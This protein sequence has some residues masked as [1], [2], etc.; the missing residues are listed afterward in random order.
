[1]TPYVVDASVI[2]KWFIPERHSES[3]LRLRS[4]AYR[5]HAPAFI[6]LEVGNVLCTKR[7]RGE[8]SEATADDIWRGFRQAPL[9]RHA[10]EPLIPAAF[11]LA[12]RTKQSLYDCLYLALAIKLEGT[13]LT[14][15]RKFF[16]A[17][18]GSQ[19]SMHV[20][21]VEDLP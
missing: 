10:D 15:D 5:L 6:L 9:R 2:L 4:P 19:Y 7:R 21:W 17:L 1:L 18:R 3:A 14:A 12:I 8:I 16:Q 13:A 20:C 11:D